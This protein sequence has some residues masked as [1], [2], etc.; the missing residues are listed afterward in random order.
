V[1]TVRAVTSEYGTGLSAFPKE[2]QFV[3]HVLFAPNR[4]TGGGE[5][6]KKKK[7]RGSASRRVGAAGAWRPCRYPTARQPW[8]AITARE[9]G[10]QGDD[11][12]LFAAASKLA[13]L[14][15]RLLRWARTTWSR[16]L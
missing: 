4:P 14:I 15:Y 13:T 1:E 11:V 9:H 7:K 2:K 5:P 10:H 3:P 16:S 12:A 6:V 8:E